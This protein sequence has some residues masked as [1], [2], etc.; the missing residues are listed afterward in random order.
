[1]KNPEGFNDDI[2]VSPPHL[3]GLAFNLQFIRKRQS[4]HRNRGLRIG[5][6][7]G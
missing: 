6:E 7:N 3:R 4:V 5:T 1:M 2:R